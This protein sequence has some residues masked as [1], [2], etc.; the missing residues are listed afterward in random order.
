MQCQRAKV[1]RHTQ[2]S[3]FL[4]VHINLIRSLPLVEGNRHCLTCIDRYTSQP[5]VVPLPDIT[6]E[7]V[8][9]AFYNV[10]IFRYSLPEKITTDQGRQF[11][12]DLFVLFTNL[13]GIKR[14]R[15]TPYHPQT[16]R[17]IEHFYKTLKQ[18]L[19]AHEKAN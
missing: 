8:A 2:A 10:W 13:L 14:T 16:N 9:G 5:E 6:A 19:K 7:T 12:S 3:R 17:K 15:I 1:Q 18:A 11:E 4:H